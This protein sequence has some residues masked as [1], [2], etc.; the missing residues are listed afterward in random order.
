MIGSLLIDFFVPITFCYV[1]LFKKIEQINT[2]SL[3]FMFSF[4]QKIFK[5][6][7]G[8]NLHYAMRSAISSEL[9]AC[10]KKH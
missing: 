10:D 5:H 3:K 2:D 9:Q 8:K 1:I 4:R 7:L 6:C